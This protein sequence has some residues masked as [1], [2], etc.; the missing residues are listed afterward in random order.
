MSPRPRLAR[1]GAALVLG[2]I[3][4]GMAL[5]GGAM[6]LYPGGTI[7]DPRH[8]GHSFWRN[9]LCDLTNDVAVNGVPNLRGAALARAGFILVAA[10]LGLVWLI[11]PSLLRGGRWAARVVRV[12]GA[13][14]ALGLIAVPFANGALHAPVILLTVV[15]ATAAMV[16]ALTGMWRAQRVV[17]FAVAVATLV[18]G[19][20]GAVLYAAKMVGALPESAL[21]V[22]LFQ[23]LAGLLL[24]AWMASVSGAVL[25][26]EAPARPH[27]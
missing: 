9:Y 14:S 22:P 27:P 13:M 16:T 17:L 23:R 18:V 7:A 11:L 6:S 1:V 19:L 4:T 3:V 15:A 26:F 20:G 21:A 8:A 12:G 2:A 5:L 25:R 24:I 10:T